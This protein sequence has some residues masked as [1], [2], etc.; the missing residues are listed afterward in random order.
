MRKYSLATDWKSWTR[1]S[2]TFHFWRFL[3]IMFA[4]SG[5]RIGPMLRMRG[6]RFPSSTLKSYV[7]R[8]CASKALTSLAAKKRPGLI[9]EH[10]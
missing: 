3:N 7:T 4:F 6:A 2:V 8:M 1:P 9:K 10:E 5:T